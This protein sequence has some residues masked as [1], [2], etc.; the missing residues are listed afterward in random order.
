MNMKMFA[1]VAALA[2]LAAP[3][4]ATTAKQDKPAKAAHV[5]KKAKAKKPAKMAPA[6]T[7][8]AK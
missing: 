5:T 1:P 3:A 2:I 8:T 7:D 4:M 6:K